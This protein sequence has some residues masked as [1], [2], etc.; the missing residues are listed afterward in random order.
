MCFIL[1]FFGL[2]ILFWLLE[3]FGPKAKTPSRPV[4]DEYVFLTMLLMD[5]I[6]EPDDCGDD[7]WEE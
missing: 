4:S 2:L 1:L 3:R 5:E 6:S 7:G